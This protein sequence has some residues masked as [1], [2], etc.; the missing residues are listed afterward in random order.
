M[1]ALQNPVWGRAPCS[2]HVPPP[3][4]LDCTEDLPRAGRLR[5]ARPIASCL[6]GAVRGGPARPPSPRRPVAWFAC[7]APRKHWRPRD[8]E[9][10]GAVNDAG[11][12]SPGGCPALSSTITRV[13]GSTS[14]KRF[15]GV[16]PPRLLGPSHS[17]AGL[18]R[19]QPLPCSGGPSQRGFHP[20]TC[21]HAALRARGLRRGL[22][23]HSPN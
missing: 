9:V 10:L 14:R 6:F 22:N 20:A 1:F 2:G 12:A 3:P 19:P 16:F 11:V 5:V 7:V 8:P 4:G 13:R 15:E 17:G 23:T 18:S 21:P